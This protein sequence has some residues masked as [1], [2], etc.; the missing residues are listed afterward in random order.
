MKWPLVTRKTHEA[1]VA[2]LEAAIES[3]FQRARASGNATVY[4]WAVNAN[5]E[6]FNVEGTGVYRAR[7]RAVMQD[8]I[9][10]FRPE[11]RSS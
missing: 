4:A 6:L 11:R 8:A 10:K 9:G 2:E 1:K 3:E 7:V 5:A